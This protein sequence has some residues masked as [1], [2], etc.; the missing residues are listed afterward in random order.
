MTN[1]IALIA[2]TLVTNVS[3]VQ[4]HEGCSICATN[5]THA[6]PDLTEFPS[7]A[8]LP[9]NARLVR[10]ET[11]EV[12]EQTIVTGLRFEYEGVPTAMALPQP[13]PIHNRTVSRVVRRFKVKQ[14]E[15]E[16]K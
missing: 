15:E 4:V 5:P 8:R 6:G 10:Q 9:V 13:V 3:N 7:I 1:I 16:L 14:V 2:V 12:L 11:T